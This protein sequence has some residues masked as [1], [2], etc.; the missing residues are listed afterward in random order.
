MSCAVLFFAIFFPHFD[1]VVS[2]LGSMFSMI[3]SI[4]FPLACYLSVYNVHVVTK[5]AM[6]AV[7]MLM[8]LMAISGAVWSLI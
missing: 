1:R 3:A 2:L 4:I 7:M 8:S 6:L 5:I